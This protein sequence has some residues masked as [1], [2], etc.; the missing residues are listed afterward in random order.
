MPTPCIRQ[1][2]A[3]AGSGKTYDLT[4]RF[5][6]HLSQSAPE[7]HVPSCGLEAGQGQGGSWGD[8]LAMTFTNSA[9]AEMK[10]RVIRQLKEIAL[11]KGGPEGIAIRPKQA[12]LWVE[13]IIRQLSALNI[14]TIDSFLHLVVRMSALDLELPPDFTPAFS[15][16]ESLT[17]LLDA[18]IEQAWQGDAAMQALLRGVCEGLLYHS[19]I[20]GFMV[21]KRITRRVMELMDGVLTGDWS[22]LAGTETLLDRR[23]AYARAYREQAA[24]LVQVL[25]R[26]GLKVHS[27][28]LK[29]FTRAR[30]GDAKAAT[31]AY[32]IKDGLDGCLLKA[33]AGKASAVAEK[34]YGDMQAVADS[35]STRGH[36][37]KRALELAP[38]V[39]LTQQVAQGL[40]AFQQAEG[41]IPGVRIPYLAQKVLTEGHG[42]SGALCRMGTRLTHIMLDEFQDTSR[43]QWQALLP[44]VQDS[45]ARGGSLTWVGDVK[46]AI[47]GWRGGDAALFDELLE[48]DS[49]LHATQPQVFKD[50]LPTNWRSREE[51]VRF[52]NRVFAVLAEPAQ[53][54]EVLFAMLPKHTPP[55]YVGEAAALLQ[56]SFASCGQIVPARISSTGGC[57]RVEAVEGE[58]SAHLDAVVREGLCRLLQED[59]GPRRPWSEVTILVRSNTA[60][61][62]VA[63]WLMDVRIPVVTENSLL[64]AEHPLVLQSVA[65][66]SFL[67]TPQD[68]VAFWTFVSGS[69]FTGMCGLDVQ[70]LY[71]WA[72]GRPKGAL[73]R[74]FKTDFPELW[75]RWLAPFDATAGLMTPYDTVQEFFGRFHVVERFSAAETFLRRFLEV[76][77]RAEGNGQ[78]TLGTFLE[79][80]RDKGVE[81]K[82][83]M[84]ENMDAVRIMTIHKSKGLQFPVVIM[85]WTA[86]TPR[87]DSPPV[88]ITLDG[89]DV[90][91]PRCKE[92]GALYYDAM[93]DMARESLHLLYVAFTRAVDE[94]HV[95]HTTTP[96]SAS[97]AGLAP[98][99]E[100]LWALAGVAL[101]VRKGKTLYTKAA[102]VQKSLFENTLSGQNEPMEP[103]WEAAVPPE[104][105]PL[106]DEEPWRPMEW[107]PQLKIFRNPLEGMVFSAKQRGILTHAC[108]EYFQWTGQPE[109]DVRRAVEQGLSLYPVPVP[110]KE[111]L[112]ADIR[113]NLQWY[114]SLPESAVW[115]RH[116]VPEQSIMD[117]AGHLHRVDLLVTSPLAR[118][119]V[120]YKTGSPT[121][122]DVLQMQGYLEILASL[123][124]PEEVYAVLVYLDAQLCRTVTRAG[125]SALLPA[126]ESPSKCVGVV[127]PVQGADHA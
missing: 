98:A 114:I 73:F 96:G 37:V 87:P 41:A 119:A 116:G 12:A 63:A 29:A 101:P 97:S 26:E 108:L 1:I 13:R 103:A 107:L 47:Y 104:K 5:L 105:A 85:P 52:N 15:T 53:A 54:V 70:Y 18:S 21:G 99:L 86:F 71:N 55:A 40:E 35:M 19:D 42:V 89:L 92:M 117:A 44:L 17:P 93:A 81:E 4:R 23:A 38:F 113:A 109:Q 60:A 36:I 31:S 111:A 127:P 123:E 68:D 74:V 49:G 76:V 50:A 122:K 16:E 56:A 64:L 3:S 8:I 61:A 25:E 126:P 75:A 66:L 106:R 124:G 120:D 90:L 65:F 22:T 9:A 72:A 88:Q 10:D 118:I 102:P 115:L 2:K 14:R 100:S 59:I 6:A 91:A 94:L 121:T 30:E 7:V 95:F 62:K 79:H 82:L 46:Q 83:P 125:L 32:F 78:A 77:Y 27:L 112:K 84:P 57:V 67:D 11:G 69:I 33:S 45:L 24:L 48:A 58:N 43:V 110:D 80:W 28:A 34:A 20:K 39:A 51:I